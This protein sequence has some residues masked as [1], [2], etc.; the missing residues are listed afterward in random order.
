MSVESISDLD[1]RI[2]ELLNKDG[3]TT[4]SQLA[5]QLK[6][7]R[8]NISEHLEILQDKGILQNF[9]ININP[10]KLGFGISAFVKLK[11]SSKNHRNIINQIDQMPEV[12]ECHVMTGSELLTMR[13]IAKDMPHLR[14]IVD[15]F[16][17]YG[18]TQTDVIF[19]TTKN[20]IDINK[21]LKRT[22]S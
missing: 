15:G 18:S 11:A 3:R 21:K 6:R 20:H 13:V 8:S 22:I 12:I 14:N 19:A 5:I 4:I 7:S 9:T 1:W 2:L 10:E 17:Q 16:T